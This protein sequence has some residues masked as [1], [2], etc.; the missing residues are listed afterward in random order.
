MDL[1]FITTRIATGGAITSPSD[2]VSLLDAGITHVIDC[3][4]ET[5]DDI[6][7]GY[8]ITL[9]RNQVSDDGQPKPSDWFDLSIRFALDALTRPRAKVLAHCMSGLNRGPSTAYA[10]VRA[11]GILGADAELLI[12]TRR[13][14]VQLAYKRDADAAIAALGYK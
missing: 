7:H 12:R 4:S 13:P 10:I 14:Q 2:V 11:F 9:L 6:L 5:D 1:T 8:P 3:C